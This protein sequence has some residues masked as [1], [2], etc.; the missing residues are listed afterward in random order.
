[1]KFTAWILFGFLSLSALPAADAGFDADPGPSKDVLGRYLS[2]TQT[3]RQQLRDV[4]MEV[5]IDAQ[6]PRLN[7]QGKLRA[8]RYIS[9]IG[10]ITYRVLRFEGDATVKKDVIARYLSAE[11]QV[12]TEEAASLTIT[13]ANYKFKYKGTTDYAGRVAHVFQLSPRQKRVGLFKGEL[14]VDAETCMPLREWGELVKNP[15]VFLKNVY[16]VRDYHVRDGVSMPRRIITE[17]DTRLVGKAQITI[18]FENV[19]AGERPEL[20]AAGNGLSM[21]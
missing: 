5:D 20:L 17:I 13:P 14:W 3:Q 12:K 2:A 15:S 7:K 18:W 9:R 21:N 1:M 6:L 11:T 19:T 8:L 10:Q 4:S 16:F